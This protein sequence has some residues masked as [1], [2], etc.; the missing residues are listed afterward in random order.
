MNPA[1]RKKKIQYILGIS[2]FYHNSAA[3]L[4]KDGKIVSAAEEERFTRIKHDKAFPAKS[5]NYCL[6]EASIHQNDLTA[7]VYY[8]NPYLT[9]ERFVHSQIAASHE[10]LDIWLDALPSWIE[11]KL[12]I[13]Q[14]IRQN[15]RYQCLYQEKK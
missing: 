6:E 14:V 7:L 5:I 4:I 3:C 9:L 8:D 11:Y 1:R 2:A 12:K 10:G 13:P 15:M